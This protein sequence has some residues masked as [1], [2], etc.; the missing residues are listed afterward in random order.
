M[1][2]KIKILKFLAGK[3][4]CMVH[5]ET[6]KDMSLHVDNRVSIK[7]N[8][9]NLV[10]IVDFSKAL[11][12][13]EIAVSDEIVKI[14]KL[15][16]GD[17]VDVGVTER[18]QSIDLIRKKLNGQELTKKEIKEIVKDIAE[19]ELRD[20]EIAFFISAIYEKGMSLRETDDLISAMVK[21]GTRLR[22][23]GKVADKHSIGGVAGN[24]TTPIVISI[25]TTT[26][27]VMP[28]TSSRAI[29]SAAGTADTIETLAKVD[30]SVQ[31]IKDILKKTNACFVWG[32][33]L[34]LAPADDRII[35]VGR[36]MKIDPTSQLLASILSKKIS[37]DSKYVLID[38]PFG[39]SAKVSKRQAEKLKTK[40]LYLGKKFDLKLEVVLTDGRNPIGMGV[41]PVLEMRDVIRVLRGD[42]DAPKDLKE[43][44][45]ILSGRIL[46]MTEKAKPGKGYELAKQILESGKAWIKFQEII[47][48]Q[49]GKIKKLTPGKHKYTIRA[50]KN[51]KI[52]HIS[53]NLIN[54]L[55]RLAGCP[56]DKSAGV[57][58]YKKLGKIKQGEK[59][60][61]IYATSEEKLEYAR[62]FYHKNKKNIIEIK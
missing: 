35:K 27:L 1:K 18:P 53:N 14:L 62:K 15:K 43:K 2:L 5:E 44:S 31:E 36:M 10:S 48:A 57:Y 12:R 6:A 30:F 39:R 49:Q 25:C 61:C 19:N 51:G 55:A 17:L 4:V 38:I 11:N 23:R 40:F 50:K 59:I 9:K 13:N 37:V 3:P 47:I 56:E 16:K 20:S 29:T 45:I 24:R 7:K 22:L 33:T 26:S 32:G 21:S 42:K 58:F 46:E 41:G 34:G 54:N 28:K 52:N 60:F 8:K